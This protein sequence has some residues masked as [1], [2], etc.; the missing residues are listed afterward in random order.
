MTYKSGNIAKTV[1]SPA[2]VISQEACELFDE[3]NCGPYSVWG[4]VDGEHFMLEG[5][6]EKLFDAVKGALNNANTYGRVCYVNTYLNR[7]CYSSA[8]EGNGLISGGKTMAK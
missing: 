2:S 7:K 5:T 1:H 3:L 4:I 8:L 6:I